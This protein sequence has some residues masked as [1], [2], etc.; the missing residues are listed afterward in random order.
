MIEP[1]RNQ[2]HAKPLTSFLFDLFQSLKPTLALKL[3]FQGV[4]VYLLL[5][6][7]NVG[8]APLKLLARCGHQVDQGPCFALPC[9]QAEVTQSVW[10]SSKPLSFYQAFSG[11]T[12]SAGRDGEKWPKEISGD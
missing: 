6:S 11:T 8:I 9:S 12:S 10:P 3:R 1:G 7:L 2:A 4:M 5:E